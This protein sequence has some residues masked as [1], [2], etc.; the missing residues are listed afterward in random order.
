MIKPT[1]WTSGVSSMFTKGRGL[2]LSA[3]LCGTGLGS[4]LTPI[5]SNWLID[6]WGWRGAF[7][8]L[9]LFWALLV[10]P[11]VFFLFSSVK[12]RHRSGTLLHAPT[13]DLTG[14]AIREG[15]ISWT[16]FKLAT[17]A[18]V[19]SLAIV[20]FTAN[21]VPIFSS[22]G[23]P[24]SEAAGIAGVIGFATVAGRLTGGYLLDRI[25]GGLV[26]GVSVAMPIPSCVLLLCFPGDL[27]AAVAAALLLGL[28]LGVELDAVAYLSTRHF[29]MRN[30]GVLF[31]TISGL[32]SLA[33]GLGPLLVSLSYDYNKTYD[34]VL[35]AYIPLCALA[36]VL[37][38]SLG[39]YPVFD[40][41]ET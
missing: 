16:F 11:A 10:V 41:S 37:F 32:L 27:H 2:A 25:N 17:A 40:K 7:V 8:G 22:Q 29:G 20:S 12:D 9:G 28:S 31:G 39:R 13:P 4:S 26:G 33:T 23:I 1:I 34:F 6:T 24:R 18:F 14:V 3:M 19:T 15:L 5:V 38:L 21:L 36:S 30:F 35:M